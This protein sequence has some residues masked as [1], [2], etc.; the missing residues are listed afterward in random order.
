MPML[1]YTTDIYFFFPASTWAQPPQ[2]LNSLRIRVSHQTNQPVSAWESLTSHHQ[3]CPIFVRSCIPLGTIRGSQTQTRRTDASR[4][5]LTINVAWRRKV[6]N[7]RHARSSTGLSRHC[8]Q[9]I[10]LRNGMTSFKMVTSQ[11]LISRLVF[12]L[13]FVDFITSP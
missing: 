8:A 10:G 3:P 13:R 6:R 2:S 12:L 5:T 11:L 4:T 9:C 1:F 7:S